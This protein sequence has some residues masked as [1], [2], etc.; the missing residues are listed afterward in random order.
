MSLTQALLSS[1][2]GLRVAQA[3]LAVISSNIAN[4]ET[5]GYVRKTLGQ[6]TTVGAG[7]GAGVRVD[8]INRELDDYVLRQLRTETAGGSYADLRARFYDRVQLLFGQPGGDGTLEANFNDFASSLQALS[9]SPESPS[10]RAGVLNA[11]Q[12]F[13]Q[14]LNAMGAGVQ[15]LRADAELGLAD[16]VALANEAMQQIA[17]INSRLGSSS[18]S[19][20]A[21]VVLK[22][23]RDRYINQLSQLMDVR[24]LPSGD[25]QV[26]VFTN[27]GIQ[28][29]GTQA[30]RLQFEPQGSMSADA[31]WNADP[32]L[33][34]LGSVNLVSPSGDSVDLLAS[35]SIRSGQIAALVEMRDKVLVEAQAQL[36]AIASGMARALS[37]HTTSG[38]P[39]SAGIQNGFDLDLAGLLGGNSIQVTY[40]DVG[41]GEER[42]VTLMRVDDP[43][44]LPLGNGVTADPNDQVFGIDFSGGMASVATQIGLA[45]GAGFTVSNP[46]GNVLRVLDDGG[47]TIGMDAMA[48]TK[49]ATGFAGGDLELPFFLDGA[50]AFSGRITSGGSQTV[51]LAGRLAVNSAL[52][53]DPSRLVAYSTT[54]PTAAGD[55]TRPDFLLARLTQSTMLFASDTGI[56]SATAPAQTTLQGFL[57][58]IISHQGAAAANA[59]SLKQGQDMVVNALQ[60]RLEETS[61][62]SID[63]EMAHLLQLQAAYAANA[64]VMQA[65]KEM[66]DI[67]SKL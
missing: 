22:D 12:V 26:T 28:L 11:A 35:K 30:A 60:E 15:G 16:S 63:E 2:A 32:S 34:S 5:P 36:D 37:D 9:T 56:G 33:S 1:S 7:V 20:T 43:S 67:L 58:E 25:N 18:T 40:T 21:A 23:Q 46:S 62:V 52:F 64:R 45:L 13:A 14:K 38:T 61:G 8:A 42:T 55:T 29:V 17:S 49:T 39:A 51:G 6:T 65:V 3:G 27:S 59:S 47:V 54:P 48:A 10:A 53:S 41:S 66:L 31:Q 44:V 24:V 4:A 50:G 57:R 19:D